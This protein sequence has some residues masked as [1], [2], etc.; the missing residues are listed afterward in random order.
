MTSLS[1]GIT[2]SH[3]KPS[4]SSHLP[5]RTPYFNSTPTDLISWSKNGF[6]AYASPQDKD[7]NNLLLTYLENIDGKSWQLALPQTINI[8]LD[9]N[10]MPEISFVSW[11]NLSTD[12]AISDVYGNFYILLAGVGLLVEKGESERS[13]VKNGNHGYAAN[14]SNGNS[15]TTKN[16]GSNGSK[17][18][19]PSSNSPPSPAKPAPSYELTSYNHMEMI[20]R[21]IICPNPVGS[22]TSSSSTSVQSKIITFKWLN[23]EKPLI[24]NKPASLITLD[25]KNQSPFIYSYGVSQYQVHGVTHPIPTKQACC[26]LRENGEFTLYFQGEHKV[27]YHKIRASL[28]DEQMVISKG[29]IGFTNDK[30]IVVTAYDLISN[31]ILSYIVTVDWGFLVESAKRQKIDPPF[32]TPKE[33]QRTPRLIVKRVDEMYPIVRYGDILKQSEVNKNDEVKTENGVK[34][35]NGDANIAKNSNIFV[36]QEKDKLIDDDL[37]DVDAFMNMDGDDMDVDVEVKDEVKAVEP[38]RS[39]SPAPSEI[40]QLHLSNLASIEVISATADNNSNLDIFITYTSQLSSTI[41]R[42]NLKPEIATISGAFNELGLRKNIQANNTSQKSFTIGLKDHMTRSGKVI[43]VASAL[44]EM[45]VVIYY[46]DGRIE[47]VDRSNMKVVSMGDPKE[48]DGDSNGDTNGKETLSSPPPTISTIFDIGFDFPKLQK[49]PPI[50]TISPNLTSF[51]Y[52]QPND[53]H[54]FLKVV[55]KKRFLGISPKELF[56][57]SVG[58]AFRH[59]YSC[60]TNTCSDD[61]IILIQYE[62]Q[63]LRSNLSG[64]LSPAKVEIVVQKFVESIISESHKAINFQLDAFSKESVDKLLS[65]PPLQKLLS[66]QLVLGEISESG[67]SQRKLSEAGHERKPSNSENLSN[68]AP[69][70]STL[71]MP[72][73]SSRISDIAWIVLNLRS[74]SFGIMFSLSSIYRQISKKKPTEDSLQDSVTRGECIMSLIGNMKWLIDLMIYLNQELQQLANSRKDPSSNLTI[75]NS[76]AIPI[77]LSMVPRLFLMYALSSIGKTHEILKKLHKDLADANKLYTPMKESLNRCFTICN[78]SPITLGVF[79]NYL[80]DCDGLITTELSS[81]LSNREKGYGLKIEQRLVCQG[82]LTPEMEYL[83]NLIVDKHAANI[84]RDLKISELYFCDVDWLD[85]GVSGQYKKIRGQ[86]SGP[87][88]HDYPNLKANMVP[89]LK[90]SS[91]ECTDVLRKIVIYTE[92]DFHAGSR[93]DNA[94]NPQKLRKCTRC[95]SVSLVSDPLVF[96][97]PSTIGL[98]TMVFQRTCICGN[99]WVNREY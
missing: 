13:D 54:L 86:A 70:L 88:V 24:I 15:N 2:T 91:R 82:E 26:G 38:A 66:L 14:G 27:E 22:S 34:N 64:N 68:I 75:K 59:A 40:S 18:R 25:S 65:N 12:L 4:Y 43:K 7:S 85:I 93:S 35:E 16:S 1:N 6:I 49:A 19:K 37:M 10:Q 60:Y 46:E 51:V 9:N 5:P 67:L 11:S 87:V 74:A 80:R 94:K 53:N 21:D 77:I 44:N 52:T 56:T 99:A 29:S 31:K 84:N 79:E 98:W 97:A 92:E 28:S 39:P 57:S 76:L 50:L 41:Y 47:V 55:E 61:L 81:K 33:S 3:N 71:P 23:I 63:R 72:S 58:F 32:H 62:I 36:K 8:R 73:H 96:D 30:E 45:F 17:P 78:S 42:Y 69:T 95:R 83:A 20:Y 90:Y 89:R 48:S